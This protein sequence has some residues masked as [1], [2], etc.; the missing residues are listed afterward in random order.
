MLAG[1]LPASAPPEQAASERATTVAAAAS[2]AMRARVLITDFL[3]CGLSSGRCDP[4]RRHAREAGI[5]VAQREVT[6]R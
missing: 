1:V 4:A 5:R 3:Q 2:P 6:I